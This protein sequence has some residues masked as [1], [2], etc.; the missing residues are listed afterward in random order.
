LKFILGGSNL[1]A[2]TEE[3]EGNTDVKLAVMLRKI[4]KEK[5]KFLKDT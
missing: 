1:D 4:W 3:E 2:N 5:I